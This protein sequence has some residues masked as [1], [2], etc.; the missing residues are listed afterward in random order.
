MVEKLL[1]NT[2]AGEGTKHPDEHLLQLS[3]VFRG[4]TTVT[5]GDGSSS[6]FWKDAWFG[7]DRQAPLMELFPRAFSFCLNEDASVADVLATTDPNLLFHLPLSTQARG[8]VRE[9][10]QG[11]L[12]IVLDS[13]QYDA[14]ECT[15]DG[16]YSSKK[17]YEHC[18]RGLLRTRP[19]S[20]SGKLNAQSNSKCSGGCY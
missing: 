3:D 9:I 4:I 14:W 20:G 11:S 13:D 16:T 2:F 15:L 18:F 19:L 17:F 5:L 6:L 8:E 7:S 12:H 1:A 10:Q